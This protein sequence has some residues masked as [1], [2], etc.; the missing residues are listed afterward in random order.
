MVIWTLLPHLT[1]CLAG[2]AV[3]LLDLRADRYFR[4][5]ARLAPHV[6][7]WFA[8]GGGAAPAI[9][10][11]FLVRSRLVERSD[12]RQLSARAAPVSIPN[13]VPHQELAHALP[14]L[15]AARLAGEVIGTWLALRTRRLETLLGAHRAQRSALPAGPALAPA[16][17]AA[18]HRAR[19]LVPIAKNC[20]L[21]S[22]ALDRWLGDTAPPRKIVVGVTAEPFLAHCWLQTDGLLLNDHPDHVR[23]YAPILVV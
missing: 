9:I 17:L 8:Q 14:R 18:Y 6:R 16:M 1:A 23:R 19:R 21:D 22:L 5:S 13:A 11:A 4:V 20:L 3:I 15:G 10:A 2:E 12:L 7:D